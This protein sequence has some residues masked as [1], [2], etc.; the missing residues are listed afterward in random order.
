MYDSGASDV[1]AIA[2]GVSEARTPSERI[3]S[4]TG[5]GDRRGV[6]IMIGG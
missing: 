6:L 1:A 3:E 5:K 4:K 2:L